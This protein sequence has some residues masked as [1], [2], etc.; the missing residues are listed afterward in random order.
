MREARWKWEDVERRGL[1]DWCLGGLSKVKEQDQV[2]DE[3]IY[4]TQE[5]RVGKGRDEAKRSGER[6]YMILENCVKCMGKREG[7]ARDKRNKSK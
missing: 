3:C 4:N 1:G 2:H 7:M 6:T 5:R